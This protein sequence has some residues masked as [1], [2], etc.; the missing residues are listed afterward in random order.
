MKLPDITTLLP[1]ELPLF[2]LLHKFI[3]GGCLNPADCA[4]RGVSVQNFLRS[5]TW[6]SCPDS[7]VGC[8]LQ[9]EPSPTH[10]HH[11][12]RLP[13]RHCGVHL[14]PGH[15]LSES[16]LLL[17]GSRNFVITHWPAVFFLSENKGYDEQQHWTAFACRHN[18]IGL[19][20]KV[21][22]MTSSQPN[23]ESNSCL[24]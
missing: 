11:P 14:L 20:P 17:Y 1:T 21:L 3:N 9:E 12:E 22:T 19:K 23:S 18:L 15:Q 10:P 5:T 13:S 16:V 8:R 4:S 7:E 6:I 2:K 24:I